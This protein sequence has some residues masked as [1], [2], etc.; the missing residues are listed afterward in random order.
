MFQFL[1]NRALKRSNGKASLIVT[2]RFSPRLPAGYIF[3]TANRIF[4][5]N[6]S[7][8]TRK[9]LQRCQNIVGAVPQAVD[10]SRGDETRDIIN[11]WVEQKTRDKIKDLIPEGT[12]DALMRLMLVNAVYLKAEWQ[13]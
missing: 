3:E 9:Y 5:Q 2:K 6:Q 10:F 13:K 11:R 4:Y 8:I 7:S 1:K 12:I